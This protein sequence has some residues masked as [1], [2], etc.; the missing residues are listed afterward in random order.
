MDDSDCNI[1]FAQSIDIYTIYLE[2]AYSDD[3][4]I[5]MEDAEMIEL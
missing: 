4:G 5:D 3:T 2:I 1:F